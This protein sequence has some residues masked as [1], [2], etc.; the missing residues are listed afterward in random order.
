MQAPTLMQTIAQ[1]LY[2]ELSTPGTVKQRG[3]NSFI[4]G[5]W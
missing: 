1:D 4:S 5:I 3:D 2:Y